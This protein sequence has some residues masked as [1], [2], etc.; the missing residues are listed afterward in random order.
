MEKILSLTSWPV[1]LLLILSN[2]AIA[3]E[4]SQP[5]GQS[6]LEGVTVQF[7]DRGKTLEDPTMRRSPAD[8][9]DMVEA[10][11]RFRDVSL[12]LGEESALR[13]PEQPILDWKKISDRFDLEVC[14]FSLAQ[15]LADTAVIEDMLGNIGFERI[16]ILPWS[17]R[18]TNRYGSVE[19]RVVRAEWRLPE[20][21]TKKAYPFALGSELSFSSLAKN[22]QITIVMNEA[23]KPVDVEV[24]FTY[25]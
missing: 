9:S 18:Q 2:T 25:F 14:I 13:F 5:G 22:L 1:L 19:G 10:V 17:A 23:M 15:F 6:P 7:L 4:A 3:D 8:L 16:D 20:N 24:T 21:S 12:C 11:E